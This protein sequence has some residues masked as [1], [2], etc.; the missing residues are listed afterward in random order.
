MIEGHAFH[1]VS[2][3]SITLSFP[4]PSV[5]GTFVCTKLQSLIHTAHHVISMAF[6]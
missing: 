3:V 5:S 2:V 1:P 4:N 6:T